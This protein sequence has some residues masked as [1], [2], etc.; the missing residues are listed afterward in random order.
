[1]KIAINV[2]HG[3][4]GLSEEGIFKYAE[5]K[6]IKLSEDRQK[7]LEDGEWF[8]LSDEEKEAHNK[9]YSEQTF[10]DR[11]IKRNDPYL[12][13]TIEELGSEA[14]SGKYAELKIVEIPDDVEWTIEKYDGLEWVAERHRIWS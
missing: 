2:K 5:L 14:A 11:D 4:F 8:E 13:Q 1:M 7:Q 6:R 10:Y 3:E 12:I 9:K